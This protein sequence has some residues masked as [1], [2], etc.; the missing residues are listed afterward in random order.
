MEAYR[1]EP[2]ARRH[3]RGE[4]DCGQ[5]DLNRFIR[6]H[7]T[8]WARRDLAQTYVMVD[9]DDPDRI[10]GY[11]SLSVTRLDGV[12]VQGLP[13]SIEIGAVLLG[14]LAVDR[15]RQ[16]QG[17]GYLLLEDA[18]NRVL[19]S[20]ERFGIFAMVVDAIDEAAAGYYERFGF[21]PFPNDPHRLFYPLKDY[22]AVR[23]AERRGTMNP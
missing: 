22:V 17:I 19:E 13:R 12:D 1:V 5:D 21:T 6:E 8:Q 11:Y 23:I 18:F 15:R 3:R 20:R 9:R 2:V 4:F 16:H 7:A 14:R 10:V